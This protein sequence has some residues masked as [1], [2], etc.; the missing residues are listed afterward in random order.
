M[1]SLAVSSHDSLE[2]ALDG[3]VEVLHNFRE[4]CQLD[5]V[6]SSLD[7]AEITRPQVAGLRKLH[8]R[9]TFALA[10]LSDSCSDLFVN[11]SRRMG[12]HIHFPQPRRTGH[13][14]RRLYSDSAGGRA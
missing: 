8:S 9:K 3:S 12:L 1:R 11:S 6:V 14:A 2:H 10:E 13:E 5:V 4:I 7:F